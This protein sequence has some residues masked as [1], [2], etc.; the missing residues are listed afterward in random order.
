MCFLRFCDSY[1]PVFPEF[2][3]ESC[4]IPE[5]VRLND[6]VLHDIGDKTAARKVDLE[7]DLKSAISIP[8][9]PYS[10]GGVGLIHPGTAQYFLQK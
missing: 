9:L 4:G 10:R 3:V 6:F 2:P 8:L 7:L 1:V 5:W